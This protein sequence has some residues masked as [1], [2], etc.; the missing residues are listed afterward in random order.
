MTET[1][2]KDRAAFLVEAIKANAAD[3]VPVSGA[4]P[5]TGD[6][7]FEDVQT[8]YKLGNFVLSP[9]HREFFFGNDV[10]ETKTGGVLGDHLYGG[11]GCRHYSRRRR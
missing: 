5:I 4:I 3:N 2:L 6:I 1:Y 7:V 11:R 8:S 10:A 9:T